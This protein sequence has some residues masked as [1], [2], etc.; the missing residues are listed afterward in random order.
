MSSASWLDGRQVPSLL[1]SKKG[2]EKFLPTC[3]HCHVAKSTTHDGL[4]PR[5]YVRPGRQFAMGGVA[6]C[7]VSGAAYL[8]R[9][10]VGSPRR[11]AR[12]GGLHTSVSARRH[13]GGLAIRSSGAL[14]GPSRDV[15]RRVTPTAGRV[16]LVG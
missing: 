16:S 7:R 14:D 13:A 2:E 6:A 12:S 3:V 9:Y 10:G 4:C 15:D 8:L 11:T 5:Q 1:H